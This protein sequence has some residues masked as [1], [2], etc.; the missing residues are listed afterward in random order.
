MTS[1]YLPTTDN[2]RYLCFWRPT[3]R[4]WGLGFNRYYV[5]SYLVLNL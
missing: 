3:V 1:L 4:Y 2:L 5:I